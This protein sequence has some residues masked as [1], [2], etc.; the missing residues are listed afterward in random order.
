MS[1]PIQSAPLHI[2]DNAENEMLMTAA[3]CR[4]V[5]GM[6]GQPAKNAPPCQKFVTIGLFFD[7]TNNNMIR[8]EPLQS[9]TNVVKLYKAHKYVDGEGVLQAP[10][11]YRIYV[12]GLGT[13]FPEN[14]EWRETADGK[15]FGKGGQARILFGLLEVYN[16][17]H[18]AFMEEARMMPSPPKS[19]NTPKT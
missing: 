2:S 15:A 4:A 3:E 5:Q 10:G 19:S 7:G 8:D 18:R 9:H 14:R 1:A 12:P 6:D 17:V 13:R 11:H 16:A